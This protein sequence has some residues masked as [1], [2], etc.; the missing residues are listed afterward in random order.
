MS[1]STM[2]LMAPA[3]SF[4]TLQAALDAGCDSVY[5]GVAQLN[6]R[7]RA[8]SN[9]ELAD[10]PAVQERC[11]ARGVRTYLTLNTLLYDHDLALARRILD[12]ARDVGVSAVICAD[13]AAIAFARERDLAVHISTQLS[14]ANLEAVRHYAR[15]A[16]TI[17]LA[18]EL[19]LPMVARITEA[20]ASEDIRGPTG[21]LV[22]IEVFG[23]GALCVAVSG[24]CGMS[25]L[26]DNTS[27]NRGSC[28]Q[29]CRREYEVTDPENGQRLRIGPDYVMSPS[30]L[31]TIGALDRVRDAGVS[32]LKLEGRGRSADY[33]DRVVRTY[34]GA[35]EALA[36]GEYTPERIA[37]WNERLGTVFNRGLSA[38]FYLGQPFEAWSRTEGNQATRRREFVGRIE[39][40]FGKISVAQLTIQDKPLG[41]EDEYQIVGDTTGILRGQG[42]DLWLEQDRIDVA[43]RGQQ[44]TFQVARKVRPGDRVFRLAPATDA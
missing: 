42:P 31:C 25:L 18:R 13:P 21:E 39:K 23:H 6:M 4:E 8:S 3:G 9:F 7:A 16:E 11:A 35:L 32:I 27:G 24:R 5:F 38:G 28:T 43:R 20:I 10:L 1:T 36:K 44:V 22:K 33:V 40:Y 14:V 17:V 26:T 30:D 19:T 29:N 12:G 15:V 37:A 41:R 2:E 34:R